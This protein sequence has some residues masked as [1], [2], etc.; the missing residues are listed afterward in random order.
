MCLL[1]PR[2]VRGLLDDNVTNGTTRFSRQIGPGGWL[3]ALA[4]KG[5]HIRVRGIPQKAA[6]QEDEGR[7]HVRHAHRVKRANK[8]CAH[9]GRFFDDILSV[10]SPWL[11]VLPLG[12]ARGGVGAE[13]RVRA[14]GVALSLSAGMLPGRH[15]LRTH[16]S[17]RSF[18]GSLKIVNRTSRR[19]KRA[20]TSRKS[21]PT[22]VAPRR[23]SGKGDQ[24]KSPSV[25]PGSTNGTQRPF[26]SIGFGGFCCVYARK[27][28]HQR[29]KRPMPRTT[30][31]CP[32]DNSRGICGI[33]KPMTTGT[34]SVR[35]PQLW[36][37]WTL[38]QM[39]WENSSFVR[40]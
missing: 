37:K 31:S 6:L 13:M 30:P 2:Q 40:R 17:R 5:R 12:H 21:R 15:L 33:S 11:F 3:V 29:E 32:K 16:L 38:A 18:T 27:L 9:S 34:Y 19:Q 36:H 20:L 22:S 10:Y 7:D 14:L 35:T 4:A 26:H 28:K 23:K 39:I 1:A 25:L 8:K 24:R